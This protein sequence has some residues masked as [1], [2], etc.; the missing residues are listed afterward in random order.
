MTDN[1]L[2]KDFVNLIE[3]RD[4]VACHA[5]LQETNPALVIKDGRDDTR[6]LKTDWSNIDHV[7]AAIA[8]IIEDHDLDCWLMPREEANKLGM[9]ESLRDRVCYYSMAQI[10]DSKRVTPLK[11][12]HSCSS[13]AK[14]GK[15]QYL[16][17]SDLYCI[18]SIPEQS[19]EE[20]GESY[21]FSGGI[22]DIDTFSYNEEE[23]EK[24]DEERHLFAVDVASLELVEINDSCQATKLFFSALKGTSI[25]GVDP[26]T[27][28][29]YLPVIPVP[30]QFEGDVED[31][32][33]H[34]ADNLS[35]VISCRAIIQ[36]I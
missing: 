19:I 21:S 12:C 35:H 26:D 27:H 31:E 6:L 1:A 8:A 5:F 24:F 7:L 23:D 3:T 34:D 32:E 11:G 28:E 13:C 29:Q 14:L 2:T 17:N 9:K 25:N 18:H 4:L 10:A 30:I 22:L 15:V 33:S 36:E 16:I 20:Y